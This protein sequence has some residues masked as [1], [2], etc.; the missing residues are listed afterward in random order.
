MI[1]KCINC[2]GMKF[3]GENM[4]TVIRDCCLTAQGMQ[5]GKHRT[6]T[7]GLFMPQSVD[8]AKNRTMFVS[9]CDSENG[10]KIR[11]IG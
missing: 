3:T 9:S 8:M 2:A 1:L 7:I 6:D 5:H 10:E 11:V 4:D